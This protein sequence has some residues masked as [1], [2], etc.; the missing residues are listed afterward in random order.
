MGKKKEPVEKKLHLKNCSYT[1]K[2][3]YYPYFAIAES[4]SE[5]GKNQKRI[6]KYLG[7]LTKK[8]QESYR[9]TLDKINTGNPNVVDVQNIQLVEQKDFLNVATLHS[10][11]ERIGLNSTFPHSDSKK[12]STAQIAEILTISKL[13]RPSSNLQTIN[14]LKKTYLPEILGISTEHYNRMK[15]FNELDLIQS[16]APKIEEQLMRYSRDCGENQF[17]IFFVD[18]T[19]SFFEGVDCPLGK[20]G[21]DKTNGYKTHMVLI[22]LVTNQSGFPCAWEVFSGD[23]KEVSEFRGVLGRI[24][25]NYDIKNTTFCFDRGFAS[26][27]NFEAIEGL[28]AKFISG[29]DSDQIEDVFDIK[30]FQATRIKLLE[31]ASS[32]MEIISK[33]P[34]KRISI[35]GFYSADNE[36]FYKEL[37][38]KKGGYRHIVGFSSEIYYAES[39]ARENS[40]QQALLEISTLSDELALAKRERDLDVAERTIEDILKKHKMTKIIS[41]TIVPIKVMN[42]GK[43]IQSG[44]I[45]IKV[46]TSEFNR[47]SYLD[48]LFIYVTDHT[49]KSASSDQYTLSAYNLIMHYKNKYVIESDFRDLKNIIDIRPLFVRLPQHVKAVV[50]IC[51]TSQYLNI[52]ITQKLKTIGMALSEF[53]NLLNSS[54]PVVTMATEERSFTKQFQIPERLNAALVALEISNVFWENHIKAHHT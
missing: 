54:A 27:G 43:A 8:E 48:G 41:F 21:K 19:T 49:E 52:Y 46:N 22:M 20:R 3:I 1:H 30:S 15:I 29:I 51:M 10:L 47:A 33:L 28:N 4:V 34:T 6:I 2:G 32:E 16:A 11:W 5:D 26:S 14:W 7:A 50:T 42:N 38:H 39:K 44:K 35:D 17:E 45:E 18:G 37:G 24:S 13:L 40:Q 31:R 36:R 25:K 12:I 23:K 9:A 53:Y